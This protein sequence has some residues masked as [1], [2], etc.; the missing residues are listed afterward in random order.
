MYGNKKTCS[1]TE[2]YNV[3]CIEL[4]F[5]E[6]CCRCDPTENPL[7]RCGCGL[8]IMLLCLLVVLLS[9]VIL[10]LYFLIIYPI[11][12]IHERYRCHTFEECFHHRCEAFGRCPCIKKDVENN[13][14]EY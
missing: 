4:C 3:C 7:L 10:P 14:D 5:T 1:C 13:M 11:M 9:P 6:L 8:L 12:Y 2:A